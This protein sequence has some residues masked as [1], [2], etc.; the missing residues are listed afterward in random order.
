[1]DVTL[2][3]SQQ[4]TDRMAASSEAGKEKLKQELHQGDNEIL[5]LRKEKED[6]SQRLTETTKQLWTR[7]AEFLQNE[8]SW[9][10]KDILLEETFR[11]ELDEKENS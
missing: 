10:A 1:M 6:L 9:E 3:L 5:S 2:H 11:K 4:E 8:K 7:G